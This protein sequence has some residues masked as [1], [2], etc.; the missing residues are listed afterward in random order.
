MTAEEA[1]HF[2]DAARSNR[3]YALFALALETGMRKGELLELRCSDIDFENLLIRVQK[4]FDPAGEP[5]F[6]QDVK[7]DRSYRIL[8]V[9]ADT[10]QLLK[11]FRS[12][13]EQERIFYSE[14]YSTEWTDLVFKTRFGTSIWH[15]NLASTFRSLL[16][17]AG[18]PETMRFH[19]LRHTSATLALTAG[20]PFR[21]CQND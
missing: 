11:E 21:P 1:Q 7:T 8:P 15:R 16:R 14:K 18:L 10:A 5:P 17:Q 3:L 19:D 4:N 6:L 13:T 20:V 2:L 9:S 12:L